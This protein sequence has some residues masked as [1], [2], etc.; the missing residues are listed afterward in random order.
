MV[1]DDQFAWIYAVKCGNHIHQQRTF[2][3][4]YTYNYSSMLSWIIVHKSD[5]QNT[6]NYS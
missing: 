5:V 6:I 2:D 3:S 4:K 1:D